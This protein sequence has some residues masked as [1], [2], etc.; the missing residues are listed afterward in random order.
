MHGT[1]IKKKTLSMSPV[2]SIACYQTL[3][4]ALD[5]DRFFGMTKGTEN[6]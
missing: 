1:I 4:M 5:L 2:I 6:G 3:Y